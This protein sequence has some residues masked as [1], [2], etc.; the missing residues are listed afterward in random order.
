MEGLR[1]VIMVRQNGR[2]GG[3]GGTRERVGGRRVGKWL[4]CMLRPPPSHSPTPSH[5]DTSSPQTG[6]CPLAPAPLTSKP[7]PSHATLPNPFRFTPPPPVRPP[8][9]HP[10]MQPLAEMVGREL[11]NRLNLFWVLVV[12]FCMGILVTY[13][14]PAIGSL[15]PLAA[16]I[17]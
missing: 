6:M 14:E 13:A 17:R 2:G 12:A 9:T 4:G 5:P 15:Q 8:P 16:L 3:G 11:P 7:F 1:V 10:S